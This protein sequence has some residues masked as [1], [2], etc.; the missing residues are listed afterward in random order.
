MNV[1]NDV[2]NSTSILTQESNI[3]IDNIEELVKRTELANQRA[4]D[5]VRLSN[6]IFGT[7]EEQ[8]KVVQDFQ[9]ISSGMKL[10]NLVWYSV[11]F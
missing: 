2:G 4:D 6:Q 7:A 9:N 5:T 3:L 1:V 11:W 10:N 8:L